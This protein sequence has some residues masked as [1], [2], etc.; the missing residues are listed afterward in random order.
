M[1][2]Y[3]RQNVSLRSAIKID[4]HKAF[5]MVRWEYLIDLLLLMGF[6]CRFVDWIKQY[7][8]TPRF[9]VNVNGELVG[10]FSSSRGI[11]QGD[12]LSPYLFSIVMK[13]LSMILSKRVNEEPNFRFHW[14][15]PRHGWPIFCLLMICSCSVGNRLEVHKFFIWLCKT[16]FLCLVSHVILLRAARS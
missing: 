11:R 14:R 7:I 8:T 15:C 10:F 1:R 16:S 6:P 9:S 5:D 4:I 3:H 2:G 13:G 12:P